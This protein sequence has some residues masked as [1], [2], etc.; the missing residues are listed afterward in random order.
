M[1]IKHTHY[2][3][4]AS[5]FFYAVLLCALVACSTSPG[6]QANDPYQGTIT[7]SGA[8]ALYPMM[9]RWAE[10]YHTLHPGV[11][12]DISAGGAGK[13]MTDV[14]SGAVDIG[15]IS[16]DITSDED[17]KG[18]YGIAVTKDAVFPTVNARNPVL[19]DLFTQGIQQATFVGIFIT[20]EVT[21]WGQVV[22]RPEITDEIHVYT[23]SDSCGAAE[24][25]AKYLGDHKQE[26]LLGIGVT[27]DPGVVSAVAKDPLGIGFNNLNY[28]FDITTGQPV[29]GISVVPIDIN[30]NGTAGPEE[31]LA[32]N[33]SAVAAISSGKYPSPPARL[34]Y[35][36]T[37]GK[38]AGLARSFIEWILQD[39]Q[40][41]V[42]ESGYIPLT[43]DQLDASLGRVR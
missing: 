17:A 14:L 34:L 6:T 42:S 11:E 27:G 13:G 37:D 26:D 36:A 29:N 16:R 4:P 43:Q 25:W 35:L 24:V 30:R 32:T 39:G 9:Q 41:Y 1:H 28:A 19:Q 22:G 2:Y 33:T 38:P 31:I 12:F 8:F 18:A 21:T 23:R 20:G 5:S 15:M 40:D 10:E 3:Y 7:I